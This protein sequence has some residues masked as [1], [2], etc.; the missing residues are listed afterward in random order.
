MHIPVH[1]ALS[2][3]HSRITARRAAARRGPYFG[4]ALSA[5]A[6]LCFLWKSPSF[7][8]PL[9]VLA[10]GRG[11]MHYVCFH[12]CGCVCVSWIHSGVFCILEMRCNYCAVCLPALIVM[13]GNSLMTSGR[14]DPV[15]VAQ[16]SAFVFLRLSVF[17]CGGVAGVISGF[18]WNPLAVKC[19]LQQLWEC[20]MFHLAFS[21]K[22]DW[23][24]RPSRF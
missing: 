23:F 11:D 10:E 1:S 16:G 8:W 14:C 17:V 6:R 22:T 7:H 19:K 20:W 21:N 15:A 9:F 18:W 4:D 13:R 24:Q 3:I 5:T 12:V 2:N